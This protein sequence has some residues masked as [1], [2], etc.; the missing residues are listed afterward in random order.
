MLVMG[1]YKLYNDCMNKF[2]DTRCKKGVAHS[3]D[4]PLKNIM[5]G[6]GQEGKV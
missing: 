2:T 6:K 3:G 5:L 1:W 4:S